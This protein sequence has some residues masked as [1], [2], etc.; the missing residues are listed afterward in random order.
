[1]PANGFCV[2]GL[3]AGTARSYKIQSRKP[4]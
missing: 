1:M 2:C 4:W 3:F